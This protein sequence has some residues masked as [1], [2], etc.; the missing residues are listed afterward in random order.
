VT[1]SFPP[2][3]GTARELC[4]RGQTILIVKNKDGLW[5]DKYGGIFAFAETDNMVDTETRAG[6]GWFS[7][8]A[9]HPLSIA[10]RGH[11]FMTSST[12]YMR[13]HPRSEAEANL[14]NCLRIMAGGTVIGRIEADAMSELSEAASWYFWDVAETRWK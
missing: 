10:A 2:G 1:K 3:F 12:A 14:L 4:F 8:S 7:L 13:F 5:K 9:D 6:I 11:D